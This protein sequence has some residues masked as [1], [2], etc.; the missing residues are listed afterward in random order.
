MGSGQLALALL[1]K[2]CPLP[3]YFLRASPLLFGNKKTP[4]Q[5]RMANDALF[6]ERGD[7]V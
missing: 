5:G 3:L 6:I 2:I 4:K 1:T 7:V